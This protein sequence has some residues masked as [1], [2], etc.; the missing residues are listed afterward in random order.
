MTRYEP[1]MTCNRAT[2]LLPEALDRTLSAAERRVLI[3][4]V[5]ACPDC[6]AALARERR[7]FMLLGSIEREPAP[8]GFAE[9]ALATILPEVARR[10]ALRW[11]DRPRL[12]RRYWLL[13]PAAFL[14]VMALLAWFGPAPIGRGGVEGMRDVTGVALLEGGRELSGALDFVES[15]GSRMSQVLQPLRDGWQTATTIER[16]LRENIPPRLVAMILLVGLSPL[17][18]LLTLYRFGIKG[19]LYH[20]LPHPL[21]R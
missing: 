5:D 9:R 16:L 8:A 20:V 13:L 11:A 10:R 14:V 15:T 3:R 2:R 19:A 7:L 12:G 6:A 21:L 4:H 18:I 17:V 1:P